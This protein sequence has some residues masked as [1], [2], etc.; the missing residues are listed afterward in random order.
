MFQYAVGKQLAIINNCPLL[1]D[2]NYLKCQGD[3]EKNNFTNR[4]FQLNQLNAQTVIAGNRELKNVFSKSKYFRR[5]FG[6]EFQIINEDPTQ[7]IQSILSLRGNIY[8][9]GYWQSEKYCSN[10]KSI[11]LNDFSVS[12]PLVG[13][14]KILSEQIQNSQSI[15]VHIRRGDYISNPLFADV[16][17]TCKPEYYQQAISLFNSKLKKTVFYV[18]SDDIRWA[19]EN[20]KLS[21]KIIYVDHNTESNCV[22]DL[23][24]MSL[25]KHNIIANSSFSW[26][27]AYLNRN[28][29]KTVIAPQLWFKDSSLFN[30]DMI[31]DSWIRI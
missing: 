29:G 5:F 15:S 21:S 30:K 14:N 27:A 1:L 20:L 12:S 16:I 22:E 13:K 26:W 10:I 3:A 6:K 8:L 4:E 24:L 25:C 18:F 11:I 23:R 17:G 7:F 2:S 28:P 31:P 9:N 19:K